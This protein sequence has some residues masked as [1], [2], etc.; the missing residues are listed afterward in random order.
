MFPKFNDGIQTKYSMLVSTVL[1][2]L[3]VYSWKLCFRYWQKLKKAHEETVLFEARHNCVVTYR[4]NKGFIGWPVSEIEDAKFSDNKMFEKLYQPIL[5]FIRTS[6]KS[7]VISVM[8]LNLNEIYSE[9][10]EAR[11]RGV[12]IRIINNF[13]HASSSKEMIY[14]LLKNGVEFQMYISPSAATD[15]IMHNKYMIKDYDQENGYLCLGSMNFTISALTNNESVIFTS[16]HNVIEAFQQNFDEC[17]ENIKIDNEGL[18]N[19]TILMDAQFD[20]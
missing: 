2:V 9:L 17:W 13:Q 7:L 15:T 14:E 1:L 11:K 5:Y 8:I 4:P 18:I 16:N 6:K 19:R 10:L 3:P 12:K 20:A